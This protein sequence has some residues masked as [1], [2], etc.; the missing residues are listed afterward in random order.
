VRSAEPLFAPALF[1]LCLA[2]WLPSLGGSFQFDD[3]NVIVGDP[4]VQSLA[5]WWQSMP[6]IRPVLKL[7]YA[8]NHELGAAAWGFRLVNVLVHACN[9]VLL[10]LVLRDLGRRLQPRVDPAGA[11]R[12]WLAAA[13]AALVFALHP[14]QSDAVSYVS[15]RSSSLAALFCLLSLWTW[16][17][18]TNA[19]QR[20]LALPWLALALATKEYALALPLIVALWWLCAESA[21]ASPI[22]KALPATVR[23]SA[24]FVLLACAAALLAAW[25]TPYPRLM[26]E[27]ARGHTLAG[28]LLTQANGV[29]YLLG[30]MLLVRPPNPDPGLPAV[31]H[32]DV[33]TVLRGGM[34]LSLVLLGGWQLRRRP[35]VAFGI[36]WFFLWLSPTNSLLSRV[37]VAYDRQLYLALA[38]PAW[39]L[40]WSVAGLRGTAARR[41]AGLATLGLCAWLALQTLGQHTVYADEVS[42]WEHVTRA[43]PGNAR[44]ANNLGMAYAV[45]CRPTDARQ[46]FAR[47]QRLD[48]DDTRA[49]VNE[50]LLQRGEL[51]AVP[52]SCRPPPADGPVTP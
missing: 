29:S 43:S 49:R 37:D 45:A 25:L 23:A 27:A 38:G 28:N 26:A 18:A 34:L 50:L 40:A 3:W 24:P 51:S 46:A 8:L 7:S 11:A 22:A 14:V 33:A 12:P 21:A 44:A 5:A 20:W 52:K 19:K 30:Q 39:L 6:G 31:L 4:R 9:A 10:F 16:S 17:R 35:A 47:A 48:P 15:G 13:G 1:L 36:L 42:F 41:F 2:V 32:P